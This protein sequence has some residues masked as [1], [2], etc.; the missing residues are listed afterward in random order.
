MQ[1]S[2]THT[3]IMKRGLGLLTIF[4]L[5]QP[6]SAQAATSVAKT[7][8]DTW[9]LATVPVLSVQSMDDTSATI[10]ITTTNPDGTPMLL[11]KSDDVDFTTLDTIEAWIPH[12][13]GD[14]VAV[15]LVEG[16]IA[17]LRTKARN[18]AGTETVYSSVI[19]LKQRPAM[20]T[21]SRQESTPNSITFEISDA[22]AGTIYKAKRVDNGKEYEFSAGI[23]TDRDVLPGRP[24]TYEFWAENG[25]KSPINTIT[26]WTKAN[27]PILEGIKVTGYSIEVNVGINNN[28]DD[29]TIEAKRE[30]DTPITLNGTKFTET[31][32]TVDTDYTYAARI[33]SGNNEESEWVTKTFRTGDG[34]EE[35]YE[36]ANEVFTKVSIAPGYDADSKKGYA[37][38]VVT[39][40]NDLSV[41]GTI[42]GVTKELGTQ[43]TTFDGLD[44]DR[45]YSLVVEASDGQ[46]TTEKQYSFRTPAAPSTGGGGISEET[47]KQEAMKYFETLSI[48][49]DGTPNST[50]A[51]IKISSGAVPYPGKVTIDGKTKALVNG[52]VFFEDL[53]DNRDYILELEVIYGPYNY[54]ATKVIHT[55]NRTAPT[56]E[57]ISVKNQNL[58]IEVRTNSKLN[59]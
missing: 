13:N 12:D 15:P 56:I 24:Y 29:V 59:R 53:D 14:T 49:A 30:D 3:A 42:E 5:L 16:E 6:L 39:D 58:I 20:P 18:G 36:D 57:G 27:P 44:P 55:P 26:M 37:D 47:F 25:Q 54:K 45:Q 28:P 32:L 22:K 43:K 11:E 19:E 50:Q 2:K 41:S 31:G 21:L 40:K 48:T 23:L 17:F 34:S 46:R 8:I 9:T 7:R 51:W 10:K 33:K 1:I 52:S 35:F 38:V 4:L